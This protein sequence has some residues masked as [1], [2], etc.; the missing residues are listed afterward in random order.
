MKTKSIIKSLLV[1]IILVNPFLV[2]SQNANDTIKIGGILRS[3]KQAVLDKANF[4]V[5]YVFE[6]HATKHKEPIQLKDSLLL[7]V[8]DM[9]SVFLDPLY[10]KKLE[11]AT[12]G[13][14]NRARKATV[15]HPEHENLDEILELVN[16]DSDLV[17]EK[18]GWPVQIYKDRKADEVTS[19]FNS[20]VENIQCKQLLSEMNEWSI[21][22]EVTDSILGYDCQKASVRYAG[23]DYT[24]WF[25]MEIP[26]SDGPWKFYGLPGLIL[27]VEDRE[28]LFCYTA[29][30]IEQYKDD[31]EIVKVEGQYETGTLRQFNKFVLNETSN[32]IASFY[33]NGALYMTNSK[34][35]ITYIPME[36]E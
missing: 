28:Q 15:V 25:T 22:E 9:H 32:N 16:V 36:I 31:V 34:N 3:G 23:R 24:A 21:I 1:G 35:P 30:G 11:L 13:R 14:I 20:Y 10:K 12:K 27:K 2:S 6:Q 29:I 7:A 17:E 4:G 26:V 5:L 8:G 18:N 33:N 19:V